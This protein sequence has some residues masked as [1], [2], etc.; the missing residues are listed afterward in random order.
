MSKTKKIL[1]TL[2][3]IGVIG[4]LAGFA[5]FSQFSSTTT[6]S[7]NTFATGTVVIGD[8]DASAAM[9]NVTNA[10][11]GTAVVKCITVTYTGSLAADV[12]LYTPSTLD[13]GAQYVD[14]DIQ[15]G[16]GTTTFPSCTGFTP[17][18]ASPIY[19]GTLA[20]FGAAHTSFADGLTT[21]PG[22]QTAWNT[23][24]TVV[25]RFT[26]NVQS[27]PLA[28]NLSISSHDFTWEAQNQ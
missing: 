26:L 28:E 14:L 2:T 4:G 8:N 17:D 5:T 3:L 18:V 7:G 24:D 10:G 22:V 13:A 6:N 16:T 12:K 1:L 21:Y 23:N 15:Q 27:N 11:P 25:Y 9:Y 19:T 20:A